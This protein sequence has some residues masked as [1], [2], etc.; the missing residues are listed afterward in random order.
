MKLKRYRTQT[1]IKLVINPEEFAYQYL[2]ITTSYPAR[3][4]D[5]AISFVNNQMKT[6]A[7]SMLSNGECKDYEVRVREIQEFER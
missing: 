5:E 1:Q 3:D 6:L 4:M 2:D 7:E